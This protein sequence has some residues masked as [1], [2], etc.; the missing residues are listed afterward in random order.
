M[1]KGRPAV[2]LGAER[3][4]AV[5]SYCVDLRWRVVGSSLGTVEQLEFIKN[6]YVT[7]SGA[8]LLL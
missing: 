3:G 6:P 4:D 5:G 1:L 8:S 2:P 7:V